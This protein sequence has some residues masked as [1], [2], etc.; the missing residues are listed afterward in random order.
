MKRI[1]R[2]MLICAIILSVAG[3]SIVSTLLLY[4]IQP[5]GT[6]N[7]P[8]TIWIQPG[9]GLPAVSQALA[10]AGVIQH[11]MRF[12][13]YVRMRCLSKK[14]RAGEYALAADMTPNQIIERIVSGKVCL[15][16]LTVPEGS[17]IKQLAAIIAEAKIADGRDFIRLSRDAGL[18]KTYNLTALSCEGYLFPDTYLFPKGV[19]SQVIM[20]T[21]LKRFWAVFTPEWQERARDLNLSVHQ[22]VTLASMIEK[23]TGDASERPIISSVFHNRLKMSMRLESDPTVIYGIEDFDGNITKRHLKTETPYNTYLIDG[24]PPGPIANP[25][26]EA[27]KAAL[28]PADTPFLY[29]VSKGDS[30][31]QFSTNFADHQKAVNKYQLGNDTKKTSKE[32]KP[33]KK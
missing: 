6:D 9:Q 20:E 32:G 16:R 18:M 5:A 19:G 21:M 2:I 31:H 28:Y 25:G 1:V 23:E 4:G 15:Y 7:T 30:T 22:I 24:L 14:L 26:L 3:I 12:R 8:R 10:E 17:D 33:R 27:L 29:F 13:L 11:P